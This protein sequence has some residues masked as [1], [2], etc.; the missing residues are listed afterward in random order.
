MTPLTIARLVIVAG[1]V[2]I[3]GCVVWKAREDA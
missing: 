3:V 1:L 2:V